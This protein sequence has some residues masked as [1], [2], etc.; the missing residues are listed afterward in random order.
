MKIHKKSISKEKPV[1]VEKD[2]VKIVAKDQQIIDSE[3]RVKLEK[4]N[5]II[6]NQFPN[7]E[8]EVRLLRPTMLDQFVNKKPISRNEFGE[9]IPLFLRQPVKGKGATG[10]SQEES[11]SYLDS[12]LEIISEFV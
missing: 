12:V 10:T 2:E 1:V 6:K 7:T 5:Y 9:M 11:R 4:L 8:S 3:L